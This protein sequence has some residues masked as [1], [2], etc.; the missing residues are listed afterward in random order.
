MVGARFEHS[1][2]VGF[3]SQENARRFKSEQPELEVVE[4]DIAAAAIAG[5]CLPNISSY[6]PCHRPFFFC[7]TTCFYCRFFIE[8]IYNLCFAVRTSHRHIILPL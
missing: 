1:V 4:D 8:W 5:H 2:G 7:C 6:P 3:L